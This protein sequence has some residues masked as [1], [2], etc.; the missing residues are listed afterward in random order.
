MA[1]Q[2]TRW[3]LLRDTDTGEYFLSRSTDREAVTYYNQYNVLLL[4]GCTICRRNFFKESC[5]E[6][7]ADVRYVCSFTAYPAL[8]QTVTNQ[9]KASISKVEIRLSTM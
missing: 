6:N 1:V 2:S 9:A 3:L 7:M 4:G 8:T 5:G